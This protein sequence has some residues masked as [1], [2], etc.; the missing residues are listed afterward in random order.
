MEAVE[1]AHLFEVG[2]E[3]DG[4]FVDFVLGAGEHELRL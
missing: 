1:A 3:T 4:T 2:D